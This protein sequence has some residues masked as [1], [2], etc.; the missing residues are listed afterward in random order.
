MRYVIFYCYV[1]QGFR[2]RDARALRAYRSPGPAPR[3]RRCYRARPPA[4]ARTVFSLAR[5]PF[6]PSRRRSYLVAA[7]R[8]YPTIVVKTCTVPN[9]QCTPHTYTYVYT[10]VCG[11]STPDRVRRFR[12]ER[13]KKKIKKY[14]KYNRIY[15]GWQR[16]NYTEKRARF[17]SLPHPNEN[18]LIA[19][20]TYEYY[21]LVYVFFF[22][23]VLSD[24]LL[25]ACS[26]GS[27]II[28]PDIF[29]DPFK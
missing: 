24:I 9:L 4:R 10:C 16:K 1:L 22:F 15:G 12:V 6:F 7:R 17:F 3:R 14:R 2:T 28:F 23:F 18:V 13:Q 27:D 25:D 19:N 11:V 20:D 29:V 8:K 26:P 21:V 5:A